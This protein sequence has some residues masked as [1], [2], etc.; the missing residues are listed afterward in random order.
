MTKPVASI[1]VP[2]REFAMMIEDEMSHLLVDSLPGLYTPASR[3]VMA[4]PQNRGRTGTVNN[5]ESRMVAGINSDS[6]QIAFELPAQFRVIPSERSRGSVGVC[7][8]KDYVNSLIDNSLHWV[9]QKIAFRVIMDAYMINPQ[10][11]DASLYCEERIRGLLQELTTGVYDFVGQD[12]WFIYHTSQVAFDLRID[13]VVDYR[14]HEY[15]R[16][17]REGLI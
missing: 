1:I 13:K 9:D 14:I 11:Q 3:G 16:L 17:K 12:T 8:V 15:T 5:E 7:L 10:D 4:L 6:G 2:I